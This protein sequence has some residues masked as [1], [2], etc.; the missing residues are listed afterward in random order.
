MGWWVATKG[1][2]LAFAG[3]TE[4]SQEAAK[5][6]ALAKSAANPGTVFQ[7]RYHMN[8]N[9][10]AEVRWEAANGTVIEVTGDDRKRP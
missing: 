2:P 7:V 1:E 8:V 3:R 4:I 6:V 5:G 10:P 9:A